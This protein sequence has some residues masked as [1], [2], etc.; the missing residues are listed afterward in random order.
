MV[1]PRGTVAMAN[2]GQPDSNGSQFFVCLVDLDARLQRTYSIFATVTEG[3]AVVD[4]IG[5]VEVL[6]V[7]GVPVDPVVINR[8]ELVAAESTPS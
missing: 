8:I 7:T 5:Q 2:T 1:Y 6:G 3:Q 4:A